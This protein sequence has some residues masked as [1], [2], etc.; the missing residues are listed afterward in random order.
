MIPTKKKI[1]MKKIIKMEKNN[2]FVVQNKL[3]KQK[4]LQFAGNSRKMFKSLY[5]K[6]F[7]RI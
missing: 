7:S 4:V 1:L 2:V 5:M 6:I 3:N